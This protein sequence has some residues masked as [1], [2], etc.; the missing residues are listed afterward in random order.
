M[1]QKLEEKLPPGNS[2]ADKVLHTIF[3]YRHTSLAL[4]ISDREEGN[5]AET[6]KYSIF[7]TQQAF[8]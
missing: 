2:G 7:K 1:M 5:I 6:R 3:T 8:N 4:K